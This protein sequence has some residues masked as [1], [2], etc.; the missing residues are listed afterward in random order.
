MDKLH[1]ADKRWTRRTNAQARAAFTI[2]V[3]P[4]HNAIGK[5]G[6]FKSPPLSPD[7]RWKLEQLACWNHSEMRRILRHPNLKCSKSPRILIRVR[8]PFGF[9]LQM[10]LAHVPVKEVHGLLSCFH[11]PINLDRSLEVPWM[12]HSCS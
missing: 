5:S 11:G 12:C 3:M 9:D 10:G 6:Q 8:T 2:A 1:E 4:A 7:L